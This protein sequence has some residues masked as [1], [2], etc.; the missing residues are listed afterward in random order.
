MNSLGDLRHRYCSRTVRLNLW[1]LLQGWLH[2]FPDRRH[3]QGGQRRHRCQ[4]CRWQYPLVL[5]YMVDRPASGAGVLQQC[6]RYDGPQPRCHKR[7]SR[8][9]RCSRFA[10]SVGPQGSVPWFFKDQ[11]FNSRQVYHHMAINS[12]IEFIDWYNIIRY[13]SSYQIHNL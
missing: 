4:G 8:R 10:L 13:C 7:Y 12:K 9:R 5:A 6:W 2:R 1:I 11:P 3:L